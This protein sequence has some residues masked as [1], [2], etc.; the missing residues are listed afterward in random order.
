MGRLITGGRWEFCELWLF[1]LVC[2]ILLLMS[3]INAWRSEGPNG[4]LAKKAL[5]SVVGDV[6]SLQMFSCSNII[7]LSSS[8]FFC[9]LFNGDTVAPQAV[10]LPSATER[11][12]QM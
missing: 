6:L 9:F 4:L 12:E 1:A 3:K 10:F 5:C 2:D 11:L 7:A 8:L